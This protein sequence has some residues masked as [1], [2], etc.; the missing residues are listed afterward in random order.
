[1]TGP[2]PPIGHTVLKRPVAIPVHKGVR[3]GAGATP[4][5]LP[6]AARPR[7]ILSP[8]SDN[9]ISHCRGER[10][11]DSKP[12]AGTANVNNGISRRTLITRTTQIAAAGALAG[13]AIP[14][15]YAAGNSTV[16]IALLGCGGRGAGAAGDA[17]RS[18]GVR[19]KLIAMADAYKDRLDT[20]FKS[21]TNDEFVDKVEVT[22]E[23]KFI[24]FDAYKHAMD[25]LSPG[26]V[27]IMATPL[28]FRPVHFAY[29]IE[30]KLNV[31]M[32]K[33]L[34]ADGASGRRLLELADEASK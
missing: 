25:A 13:I 18:N 29:A 26:D 27:V 4:S 9:P 30:K 34:C 21:L 20:S 2:S 11:M 33:P 32:E 12:T 19:P 5:D 15:V 16:Q 7:K 8:G 31:F 6:R 23:R 28:A 17:L 1:M 3:T 14:H 24:G 10:P 22:N